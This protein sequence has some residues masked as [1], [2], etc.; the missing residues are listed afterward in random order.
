M[1][2]YSPESRI[3][4]KTPGNT[5]YDILLRSSFD[6]LPGALE[7]IGCGGRRICI[8]TDSVVESHYLDAVKDQIRSLALQVEVFVFDAGESSKTLST[9]QAL[10]KKL[11]A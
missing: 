4:I 3:T 10:Y 8:V 7:Q 11:I 5:A 6:D 1:K 9:V 2:N